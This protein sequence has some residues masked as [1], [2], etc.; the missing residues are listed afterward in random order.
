MLGES[1][2]GTQSQSMAPSGATRAPVRQLDRNP[3]SAIGVNG[4]GAEY[5]FLSNCHT[6][7][8]VA[9]DGAIDWLCVPR[10]DS[11]SI[12]GSL[13]DRGAG[14]LGESNRGHAEPSM[15]RRAR[16]G[17]GMKSDRNRTRRSV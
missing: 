10:F 8:L 2:R 4:D 14:M 11:P 3:Y 1:M 16:R 5:G 7:A 9:P 15:A 12:F 13:L 6:G 17:P